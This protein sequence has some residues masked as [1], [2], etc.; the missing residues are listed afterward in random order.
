MGLGTNYQYK[1]HHSYKFEGPFLSSIMSSVGMM[2]DEATIKTQLLPF[3]HIAKTVAKC[4]PCVMFPD[5]NSCDCGATTLY[6]GEHSWTILH[7]PFVQCQAKIQCDILLEARCRKLSQGVGFYHQGE[8]VPRFYCPEHFEAVGNHRIYTCGNLALSEAGDL[9]ES[10]QFCQRGHLHHVRCGP[11]R[12]CTTDAQHSR[13]RD[14]MHVG[15]E[16][17]CVGYSQR[18]HTMSREAPSSYFHITKHPYSNLTSIPMFDVRL[19]ST[20]SFPSTKLVERFM[21]MLKMDDPTARL[22]TRVVNTFFL[23]RLRKTPLV[24]QFFSCIPETTKC[25]WC[26]I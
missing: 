17:S 10:M 6:P 2:G 25:E 5:Y 20:H 15:W 22:T 8:L 11:C 23:S 1:C 21:R 24:Y 14:C 12:H 9:P 3:R 4:A 19:E 26:A 18:A 16:D 7:G 13:Q